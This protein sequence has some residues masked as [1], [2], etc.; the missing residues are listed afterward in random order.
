M[1]QRYDKLVLIDLLFFKVILL[2]KL[3]KSLIILKVVFSKDPNGKEPT[4]H[5]EKLVN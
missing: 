4:Q 5:Y 2:I 1:N 3:I